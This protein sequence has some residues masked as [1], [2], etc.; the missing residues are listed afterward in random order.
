M[1]DDQ[2]KLK[3]GFISCVFNYQKLQFSNSEKIMGPHNYANS[4][5]CI[6]EMHKYYWVK[7]Y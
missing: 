4:Y 3:T 7:M 1:T 5:K 6:I 2:I